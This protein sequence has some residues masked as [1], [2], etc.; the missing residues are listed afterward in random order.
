MDTTGSFTRV[1]NIIFGWYIALWRG[2]KE[3]RV[4]KRKERERE[5]GGEMVRDREKKGLGGGG[6]ERKD[7]AMMYVSTLNNK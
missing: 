1:K 7:K 5:R 4:G 2:E 3:G 6:R